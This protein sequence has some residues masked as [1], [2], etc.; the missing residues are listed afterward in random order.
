MK[1]TWVNPDFYIQHVSFVKASA[2]IFLLFWVWSIPTSLLVGPCD[3]WEGGRLPDCDRSARWQWWWAARAS[4]RSVWPQCILPSDWLRYWQEMEQRCEGGSTLKERKKS[5]WVDSHSGW[6]SSAF[7]SICASVL[8]FFLCP[9]PLLPVVLLLLSLWHQGSRGQYHMGVRIPQG[10]TTK[11]GRVVTW[12]TPPDVSVVLQ[13]V[14]VHDWVR[15]NTH[16]N[17]VQYT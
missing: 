1:Y 9:L 10:L 17:N 4:T 16:M 13:A 15:E 14:Q 8:T 6:H 5:V 11:Q 3:T 2:I 12:E 7:I